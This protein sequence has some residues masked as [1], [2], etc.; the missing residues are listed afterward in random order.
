M[1]YERPKTDYTPYHLCTFAISYEA[2][3]KQSR[4]IARCTNMRGDGGAR[5]GP[6]SSSL[7]RRASCLKDGTGRQKIVPL[8]P[9]SRRADCPVGRTGN[10][11]QGT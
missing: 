11:V 1:S 4:D 6:T 9:G 7:N 10:P 5:W 3:L 2:R 8:R